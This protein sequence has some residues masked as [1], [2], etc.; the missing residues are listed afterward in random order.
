MVLRCPQ[1]QI[2]H[3]MGLVCSYVLWFGHVGVG[4]WG[5]GGAVYG[6]ISLKFESQRM[7]N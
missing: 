1:Y 7:K 4:V 2:G 3:M 5:V 6:R